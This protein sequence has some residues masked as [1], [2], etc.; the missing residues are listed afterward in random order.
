MSK[1]DIEGTQI[2]KENNEG[3]D[4][5]CKIWQSDVAG[6]NGAWRDSISLIVILIYSQ[7]SWWSKLWTYFEYDQDLFRYCMEMKFVIYPATKFWI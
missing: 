4:G 6:D 5:C 7:Y 3:D 2:R 1:E